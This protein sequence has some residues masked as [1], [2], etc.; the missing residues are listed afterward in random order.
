M[1]SHDPRGCTAWTAPWTTGRDVCSICRLH[2]VT[3][4]TLRLPVQLALALAQGLPP[5]TGAAASTGRQAAH[6]PDGGDLTACARVI[7]GKARLEAVGPGTAPRWPRTS[8]PRPAL[9]CPQRGAGTARRLDSKRWSHRSSSPAPGRGFLLHLLSAHATHPFVA[10]SWQSPSTD[11]PGTSLTMASTADDAPSPSGLTLTPLLHAFLRQDYDRVDPR[12]KHWM[13]VL[14]EVGAAA[15]W[16]K[17]CT[18]KEHLFQV[19][20]A[21]GGASGASCHVSRG[22]TRACKDVCNYLWR[23]VTGPRRSCV[24]G[25]AGAPA[26]GR[27]DQSTETAAGGRVMQQPWHLPSPPSSGGGG[28]PHLRPCIRCTRC[29]SCG[30][31]TTTCACAASSTQPTATGEVGLGGA[32]HVMDRMDL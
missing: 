21:R 32:L 24:P 6:Q 18:F 5:T 31:R 17:K 14:G 25:P 30:G 11:V 10:R 12:L 2:A 29:S 22:H 20:E 26:S 8:R 23:V 1:G 3:A 7:G 19:G 28:A 13:E 16:H 9:V 4:I 15:C 27:C